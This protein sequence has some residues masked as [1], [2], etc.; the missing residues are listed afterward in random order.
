MKKSKECLEFVLLWASIWHPICQTA[1]VFSKL[2]P[3]Y[4]FVCKFS[5]IFAASP[6]AANPKIVEKCN[7]TTQAS[8]YYACQEDGYIK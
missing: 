8:A 4:G 5:I 6:R 3:I 1:Q 2:W 7:H